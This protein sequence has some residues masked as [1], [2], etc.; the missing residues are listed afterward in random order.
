MQ[1]KARK[2][3]KI[4]EKKRIVVLDDHSIV[5]HGLV[6]LVEQV[7]GVEV[8]GET[9]NAGDALEMIRRHQPDLVLVDLLLK[10]VGGLDLIKQVRS[11][12]EDQVR[13]LVVSMHDEKVF[14]ERAIQAGASGYLHKDAAQEHVV[15]AVTA[16][17]GGRIYISRRLADR[18]VKRTVNRKTTEAPTLIDTLSDRELEVFELIGRGL[19]AKRIAERLGLSAKTVETYRQHIKRKLDLADNSEL[20]TCATEWVVGTATRSP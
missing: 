15:E 19:T 20:A 13:T 6:K 7:D 11:E 18:F 17:L 10:D 3:A 5:R 4:K 8:V 1:E 16:V 2:S 12:F 14:A 9:D